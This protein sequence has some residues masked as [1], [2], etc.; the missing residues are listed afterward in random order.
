MNKRVLLAFV[1]ILAMVLSSSCSLVSKDAAV[2][3]ATPVLEVAGQVFTK[4]D[5]A[6]QTQYYLDY[7]EYMYYYYYGMS[8][9]KAS[10]ENIAAAQSQ[11]IEYLTQMA[12]VDAKLDEYGFMN[13]TEEELAEIEASAKEDFQLYYD[14]IKNFVFYNTEMEG[15]EL[16]A[17]IVAE[18]ANYGYPD[19]ATLV[20]EKKYTLAQDKLVAEMNKDITV[21]E[22]ELLTE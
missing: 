1:L 7:N 19:E 4:G 3:N 10:A 12:V 14:T 8:Y 6:E 9:D 17:A 11:A 20:A 18:M 5:V 22:E 21:S 13:H 2:D 15:D 16:H